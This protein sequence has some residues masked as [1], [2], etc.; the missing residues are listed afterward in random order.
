MNQ[1]FDKCTII[2]QLSNKRRVPGLTLL[3]TKMNVTRSNFESVFESHVRTAIA[4]ADFIA[5][6]CEMSGIRRNDEP[7][8]CSLDSVQERYVT[9]GNSVVVL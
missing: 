3:H 8:T 1:M 5:F 7:R 2:A 9:A 6:D 4:N